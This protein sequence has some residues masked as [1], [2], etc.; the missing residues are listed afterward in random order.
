[1]S[2]NSK[3]FKK[4]DGS[5]L[6]DSSSNIETKIEGNNN[7]KDVSISIFKKRW[8]KFKTLKR[9][10]YSFVIILILYALSLRWPPS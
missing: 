6:K 7:K 4:P 5:N 2:E 8:K 1:M 9:G 10:Y 3:N